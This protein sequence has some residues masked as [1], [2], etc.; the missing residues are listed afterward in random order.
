LSDSH[1]HLEIAENQGS[2]AVRLGITIG[3][4]IQIGKL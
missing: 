3:D 1:N 4:K 2:G